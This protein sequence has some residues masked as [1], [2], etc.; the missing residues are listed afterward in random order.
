MVWLKA[1][2][3]LHNDSVVR[4]LAYVV[5]QKFCCKICRIILRHLFLP[6]NV[7]VNIFSV[8]QVSLQSCNICER[9]IS[10]NIAHLHYI[11]LCGNI[12]WQY[13]N[14]KYYTLALQ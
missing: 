2:V 1:F 11:D 13:N 10:Q 6:M 5:R 4:P 7:T 8:L 14:A 12:Y 9:V 3:A